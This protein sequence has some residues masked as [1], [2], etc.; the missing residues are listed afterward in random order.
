MP[1]CLAM[2]NDYVVRFKD[3]RVI[4]GQDLLY[5]LTT[6]TILFTPYIYLVLGSSRGEIEG[7]LRL[8]S[9]HLLHVGSYRT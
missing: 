1:F 5:S 7:I 8:H 3:S 6:A 9:C 4:G 2:S